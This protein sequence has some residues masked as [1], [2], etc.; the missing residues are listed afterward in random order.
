[1]CGSVGWVVLV[2]LW[3]CLATVG[4]VRVPVGAIAEACRK[5]GDPF[6][7]LAAPYLVPH[8]RTSRGGLRPARPA[9]HDSDTVDEG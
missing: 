5:R 3:V 8:H 2:V 1:M 7:E 4:C 9:P 6:G